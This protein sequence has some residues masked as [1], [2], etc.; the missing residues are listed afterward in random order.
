MPN[1]NENDVVVLM[2]VGPIRRMDMFRKLLRMDLFIAV[3]G[4]HQST[5]KHE[6]AGHNKI[7]AV[8]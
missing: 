5:V 6:E 3:N 8:R 1:L 7:V 2:A 4:L